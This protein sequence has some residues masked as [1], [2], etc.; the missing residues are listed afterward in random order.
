M[1]NNEIVLK[2]EA[3]NKAWVNNYSLIIDHNA[4]NIM[5]L[6][7]KSSSDRIT[8]IIIKEVERIFKVNLLGINLNEDKNIVANFL[9]TYECFKNEL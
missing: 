3:F 5:I 1:E 7:L 4:N 6:S 2:V 9:N 8:E